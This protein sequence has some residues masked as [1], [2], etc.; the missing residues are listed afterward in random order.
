MALNDDTPKEFQVTRNVSSTVTL[1]LRPEMQCAYDAMLVDADAVTAYADGRNVYVTRGMMGFVQSDAELQFVLA[2][3]LAHNA[4]RHIDAARQNASAGAIIGT[5]VGAMA[6]AAL[7]TRTGMR[8]GAASGTQAGLVAYSQDFEREA[9]YLAAYFL[10]RAG[11]DMTG[12]EEFWRRL[13]AG[14]GYQSLRPDANSSHPSYPERVVRLRAV[15]R[16]I[17]TRN[18]KRRATP[19]RHAAALAACEL[20]YLRA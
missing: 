14:S 13:G 6:D 8:A 17:N 4:A 2:H 12:L 18:R 10:A 19:A 16:E 1:A 9:D 15:I 7:G 3:E 20:R 11:V 5:I